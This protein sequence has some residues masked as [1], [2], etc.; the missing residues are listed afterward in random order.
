MRVD[1]GFSRRVEL[2]LS[3]AWAVLTGGAVADLAIRA[4]LR[5]RNALGKVRS[6][7]RLLAPLLAG[8]LLSLS[9]DNSVFS[10]EALKCHCK[11]KQ[12]LSGGNGAKIQVANPFAR[13]I[14]HKVQN[15]QGTANI[16]ILRQILLLPRAV[17]IGN[18]PR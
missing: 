15:T 14:W 8:G 10:L 1:S 9:V 18:N 13:T 5:S 16:G 6:G 17:W 2:S 11:G 4:L 12:R 7:L 3:A